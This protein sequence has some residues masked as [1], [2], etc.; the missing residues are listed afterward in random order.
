MG[1][2]IF[3]YTL[4]NIWLYYLFKSSCNCM[5]QCLE[6]VDIIFWSRSFSNK[7]TFYME[8]A[9]NCWL[10]G[11]TRQRA[12]GAEIKIW[13]KFLLKTG[14]GLDFWCINGSILGTYT[15]FL[16]CF[17]PYPLECG[18]YR[19]ECSFDIRN[20]NKWQQKWIYFRIKRIIKTTR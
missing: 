9:G 7:N 11:N 10:L 3:P 2:F 19:G 1:R 18:F 20:T 17:K 16:C 6:S 5:S 8:Q 4:Q 14:T 13:L 12:V 15:Y